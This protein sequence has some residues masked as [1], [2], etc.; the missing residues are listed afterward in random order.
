MRGFLK[1]PLR[2]KQITK[3]Y[4]LRLRFML[5]AAELK[6]PNHVSNEEKCSLY[7]LSFSYK[8]MHYSKSKV[9]WN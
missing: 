6:G 7:F 9:V 1:Q 5:F 3:S 2:P 4:A 8:K